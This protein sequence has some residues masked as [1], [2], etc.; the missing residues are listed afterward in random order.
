MLNLS[1]C[2]RCDRHCLCK[3]ALAE[4]CKWGLAVIATIN[5]SPVLLT[6]IGAVQWFYPDFDVL[7]VDNNSTQ[8]HSL[9]LL[10]FAGRMVKIVRSTVQYELGANR[11]PC[12]A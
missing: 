8:Q 1:R 5:Q 12:N 10:E 11:S 7:V 2:R 9:S 4:P 3:A 6:T